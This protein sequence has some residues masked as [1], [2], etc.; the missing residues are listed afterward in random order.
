[1]IKIISLGDTFKD[2][3]LVFCCFFRLVFFILNVYAPS[4]FNIKCNHR[5]QDAAEKFFYIVKLS[6]VL[7]AEERKIVHCVLAINF[8]SAHSES[9]L[10]GM[11]SHQ[12]LQYRKFALNLIF[13]ARRLRKDSFND[14]SVRKF[15]CPTINFDAKCFSDL[16]DWNSFK[17]SIK[18]PPLTMRFCKRNLIAMVKN[19]TFDFGDYPNHTQAVE[20]MVKLVTLSSLKHIGHEKRQYFILN[21][22]NALKQA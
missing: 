9:I 6:K 1:M 12:N 3:F 10:I 14:S 2:F 4:W 11:L 7:R 18:E 19:N 17:N 20:R 21:I 8:F 22:L 15:T 16:V 5:L 13:N